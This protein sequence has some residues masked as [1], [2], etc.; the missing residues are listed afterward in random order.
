MHKCVEVEGESFLASDFNLRCYDSEWYRY[1]TA[2]IIFLIMYPVG[3]PLLFFVL[4]WRNRSNFGLASVRVRFGFV[5]QG[6]AFV[7]SWCWS[8]LTLCFP[9]LLENCLVV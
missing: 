8:V 1:L 2:N 7:R 4:L 3:I 9:R 5:F 6:E